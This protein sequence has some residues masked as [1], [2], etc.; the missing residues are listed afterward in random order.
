MPGYLTFTCSLCSLIWIMWLSNVW[1]LEFL[2]RIEEE[3]FFKGWVQI[4]PTHRDWKK[5]KWFLHC[6]AG[7]LI[8]QQMTVKTQSP[9]P[10]P[11][12][13]VLCIYCKKKTGCGQSSLLCSPSFFWVFGGGYCQPGSGLVSKDSRRMSGSIVNRIFVLMQFLVLTIAAQPWLSTSLV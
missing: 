4:A 7:V 5:R 13:T 12:L 8:W 3:S 6:T 11:H 1:N 10:S 2:G 9:S